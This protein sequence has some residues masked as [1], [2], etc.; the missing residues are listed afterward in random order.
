MELT[1]ELVY[2]GGWVVTTLATY[3]ASR[4]LADGSTTPLNSLCFSLLAGL[5]WPLMIIGVVEFSSVAVYSTAK[6]RRHDPDVPDSWLRVE[7]FDQVV[8]PLR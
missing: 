8:V 1:F 4:R 5:L 2:L 7:D 3:V 6:S